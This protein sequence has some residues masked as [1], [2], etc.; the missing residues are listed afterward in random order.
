[1]TV[2]F[3]EYGDDFFPGTGN[4]DSIG[5]NYSNSKTNYLGDGPGRF[6]SINVPLKQ[7]ITDECYE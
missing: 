6:H 1:M 5:N 2:S 4:I 3:H 7:G